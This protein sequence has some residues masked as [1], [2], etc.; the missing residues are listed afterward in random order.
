MGIAQ[1]PRC[2]GQ[3]STNSTSC[4]W[5]GHS[6]SFR[7]ATPIILLIL[8]AMGLSFGLGLIR[9][10]WLEQ[11]LG[12]DRGF[13]DQVQ[14]A[15]D[16]G[17]AQASGG[18]LGWRVPPAPDGPVNERVVRGA[19]VDGVPAIQPVAPPA[20]VARVVQSTRPAR[21]AVGSAGCA[22]SSAVGRLVARYPAWSNSD[23]A[24]IACG[25]LRSGFSA[26]QVHASLGTPAKVV[27]SGLAREEWRYGGVTV[28]VEKGRVISFG[29]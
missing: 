6:V 16:N 21:S 9:W 22:D 27:R 26:D 12:L 3:I 23:L 5:C 4:P 19:P 10:T 13:V 2:G 11:T 17:T 20:R 1:C 24:L 29:Q 25:R 8:L 7:L 28:L 18:D 15:A 14:T